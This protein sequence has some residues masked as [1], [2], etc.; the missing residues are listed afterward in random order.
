MP[1]L[2]TKHCSARPAAEAHSPSS[3]FEFRRHVSLGQKVSA[4]N[5]CFVVLVIRVRLPV[6]VFEQLHNQERQN[7]SYGFFEIKACLFSDS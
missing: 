2:E 4:V 6:V 3:A 1:Q 5:F 7:L